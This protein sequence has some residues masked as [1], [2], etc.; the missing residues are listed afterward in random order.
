MTATGP[1]DLISVLMSDHREVERLFAELEAREGTVEHRRELVDHVITEVASHVIIEET[2]MFPV[3]RTYV[4]G[5]DRIAD[6]EMKEHVETERVMKEL[7]GLSP[8]ES[9]FEELLS[10]FIADIRRQIE[11]EENE[12]FPE[13]G[14][15]CPPER[16]RELGEKALHA[17]ETAPTRP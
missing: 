8:A 12:I 4:E 11:C 14:K 17:K 7:E 5:G 2:W 10:R 3:F 13:L 15:A 1:T 16:L 6:Q 9:H